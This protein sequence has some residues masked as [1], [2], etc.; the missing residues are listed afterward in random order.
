M[1]LFKKVR[2]AV[3]KVAQKT[4]SVA[5]RVISGV[6]TGGTTEV[7]RLAGQKDLAQ[8]IQ[9][10]LVPTTLEEVGTAV[11]VASIAFT[12]PTIAQGLTAVPQ[13]VS[14]PTGGTPMAGNFL[15]GLS[16]VLGTLGGFGGGVGQVA[17]IGSSFLS[18]FLPA[19]GPMQPQ[20]QIG[21]PQVVQ[22]MG[23]R[24]VISGA[25]GAVKEMLDPVLKKLSFNL[26][27]NISLRAAMI[28]IRR[29]GKF[30]QT[31]TAIGVA[32][33]LSLG[34]LGVILTS[35]SLLGSGGRR[36]NAGN[37]KALRRAHRRVKSFHKLCG[38]ND[39]LKA[40]RRRAAPKITVCK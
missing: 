8:G 4:V 40:S 18:G 3:K 31:P 35:S 29:L 30:L 32:L 19:Q 2:R 17:Q 12:G 7:L 15:G 26:G 5:P 13:V 28:I 23:S 14:G 24:S 36:M 27:K 16:G 10:L 37:V 6:V 20:Q 25:A 9:S 34:E 39:R 21:S 22:V 33:G 38:E 11:N 1:G